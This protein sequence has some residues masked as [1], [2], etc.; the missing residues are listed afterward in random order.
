MDARIPAP[1]ATS[2]ARRL[3]ERRMMMNG[4][5]IGAAVAAAALIASAAPAQAQMAVVDVRAV[6]QA[7]QTARNTL[8][9]LQEEQ[10]PYPS[11]KSLST[12]SGVAQQLDRPSLSYRPPRGELGRETVGDKGG[13]YGYKTGC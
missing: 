11:M 2:R 7:L 10:R 4:R 6:A 13:A 9:Q 12:I 8:A 5:W 1:V 3:E